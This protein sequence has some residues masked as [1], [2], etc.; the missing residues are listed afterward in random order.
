METSTIPSS[1]L[2][3]WLGK[4]APRYTSY[5]PAPYFTT[6]ITGE[7]Y[8][9]SLGAIPQTEAISLYIHIPFC[10]KLCLYCGCNTAVTQRSARIERYLD[11]IK[12]ETVAIAAQAGCRRISHLHFG[13][14]TPNI[15][16]AHAMQD[17]FAHL[18]RT[19]DFGNIHESAMEL[20]PRSV[21]HDQ[22]KAMA[23]CGITR[24]S[25]GVQDFNPDVQN[26]VQRIQSYETVAQLCG[27]LRD[28]GINRIN[29]DLMYGLPLQTPQSVSE[30]AQRVCE[31]FPDRIALFSYAHVPQMKRHQLALEEYGIPDAYQKLAMDD[32]ARQVL[33]DRGYLALGMDHFAK[34]DD[35]MTLAWRTGTLRR[36]FQG[37][38][39]DKATTLIGLGASSISQ[40]PDGYF[41][42]E[43]DERPYQQR[44]N[45]G[46]FATCRGFL[47]SP[48]D[49]V[50]A[51]IIEQLMCYLTCDIEAI[52]K[53]HHVSVQI[54]DKQL[55]ALRPYENAG[56]VT[57]QGF[58]VSLS[59]PHRMAIRVICQVFDS[60]AS[61]NSVSSSRAA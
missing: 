53:T 54:F 29:F 61:S 16:S 4:P 49:K 44:V 60:Y 5:P 31:L 39:D 14:G 18:N 38:T 15:M 20:D 27:W 21:T 32:T 22:V 56:L 51:A 45:D 59:T 25:L 47:L 57:R 3:L 6:E 42:N 48:Q 37:Y 46:R 17:L 8:A 2:D 35:A 12:R 23:D 24:V 11:S 26:I 40:T 7:N 34:P 10:H 9:Q 33:L 50:Q 19:F 55:S 52:C 30:T 1:P 13:G 43:R 28:A 58:H 36:N 41:Q